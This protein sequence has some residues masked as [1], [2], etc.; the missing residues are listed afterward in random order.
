LER[1]GLTAYSL[2]AALLYGRFPGKLRFL[3]REVLSS[4]VWGIS[5]FLPI[6]PHICFIVLRV[7]KSKVTGTDKL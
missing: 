4:G 2:S 3:N 1:Y 7:E 6:I 5:L